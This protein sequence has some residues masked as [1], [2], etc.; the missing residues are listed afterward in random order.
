M[1]LKLKFYNLNLFLI[2]LFKIF[3]LSIKVFL[4]LFGIFLIYKTKNL[5]DYLRSMIKFIKYIFIKN[6][7]GLSNVNTYK[8]KFVFFYN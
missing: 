1:S 7:Q 4:I 5:F 6:L 3:K 2:I 8:T